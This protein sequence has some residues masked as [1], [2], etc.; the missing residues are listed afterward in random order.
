MENILTK[1]EKN[2]NNLLLP[3][4]FDLSREMRKVKVLDMDDRLCRGELN[5]KRESEELLLLLICMLMK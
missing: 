4:A 1:K 3:G 2:N 5:R